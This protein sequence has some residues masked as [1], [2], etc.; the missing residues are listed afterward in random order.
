MTPIDLVSYLLPIL[1]LDPCMKLDPIAN[2]D[3]HF[4]KALIYAFERENG[5]PRE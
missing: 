3:I 4:P 2:A 5:R 1:V